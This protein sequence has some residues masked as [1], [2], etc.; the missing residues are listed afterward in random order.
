MAETIRMVKYND[1]IELID[2]RIKQHN[3]TIAQ[4]YKTVTALRRI[5]GELNHIKN[6]I[7]LQDCDKP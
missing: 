2:G 4:T 1:I 5:V 7:E 6:T 3:D